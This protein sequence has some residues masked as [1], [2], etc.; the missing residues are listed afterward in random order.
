VKIPSAMQ[1]R[2]SFSRFIAARNIAGTKESAAGLVEA[3]T[4]THTMPATAVAASRS[5][6]LVPRATASD[7]AMPAK[8]K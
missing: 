5:E 6:L 1:M 4:V 8:R 2:A 3:S 7:A